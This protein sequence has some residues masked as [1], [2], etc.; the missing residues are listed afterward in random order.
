[1]ITNNI[2]NEARYLH[3]ETFEYL[4]KIFVSAYLVWWCRRMWEIYWKPHQLR[5]IMWEKPSPGF[6]LMHSKCTTSNHF[7]KKKFVSRIITA[8]WDETNISLNITSYFIYRN[9]PCNTHIHFVF[10]N[11]SKCFNPEFNPELILFN[12][13]WS[14]DTRKKKRLHV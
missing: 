3:I 6:F 14:D 12:P 9:F 7:Y 4:T 10:H 11:R 8:L 1:M 13:T 2:N 5:I